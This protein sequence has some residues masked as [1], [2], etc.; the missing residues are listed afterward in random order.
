MSMVEIYLGRSLVL[1]RSGKGEVTAQLLDPLT[2]WDDALRQLGDAV[3]RGSALAIHL[4]AAL[5]PAIL[6]S[7]PHGLTRFNERQLFAR[8]IAAS[9]LG[10]SSSD[11]LCEADPI[12]ANPWAALPV[13]LLESINAWSAA[14][15]LKP[16]SLRPLWSLVSES[17]RVRRAKAG[18]LIIEPD[19]LTVLGPSTGFTVPLVLGTPAD[20]IETRAVG[21][22]EALDLPIEGRE[23]LRLSSAPMP[24][25]TN[26]P[27][28]WRQH[29][30]DT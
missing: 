1:V 28:M 30:S 24:N 5:C 14:N 6:V 7:Y 22:F 12:R 13:Q 15:G 17:A 16:V 8:N 19:A 11:V 2:P 23:R 27:S 26:G 10:F 9:Q 25:L 20:Q 29:W 3:P 18:L 4:S 21:M